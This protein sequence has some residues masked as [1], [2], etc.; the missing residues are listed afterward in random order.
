MSTSP[1]HEIEGLT[2]TSAEVVHDYV[3]LAFGDEIGLSI[4]NPIAITPQSISVDK[5]IGRI[6]VS[7]SESAD[8]IELA[9]SDGVFIKVD[10]REQAYQ[11][12]EA[13]QLDR[14]GLPIVIW[15]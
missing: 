7:A 10:M 1:L 11:G 6:V 2:V 9:F 14:K 8:A 15:N 13:L 5:L 4:Y 12:P 3:Q